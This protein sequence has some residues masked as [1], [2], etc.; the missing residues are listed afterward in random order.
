MILP[1]PVVVLAA[2]FLAAFAS[3]SSALPASPKTLHQLH[4]FR[5]AASTSTASLGFVR[6]SQPYEEEPIPTPTSA[7]VQHVRGL[8]LASYDNAHPGRAPSV[9]HHSSGGVHSRESGHGLRAR[10]RRSSNSADSAA[11]GSSSAPLDAMLL[12]EQQTQGRAQGQA[13]HPMPNVPMFSWRAGS[14]PTH[15]PDPIMDQKRLVY[16]ASHAWHTNTPHP[17]NS[18]WNPVNQANTQNGDPDIP[19][20]SPYAHGIMVVGSSNF[21]GV[22]PT[23]GRPTDPRYAYGALPPPFPNVDTPADPAVLAVPG[24]SLGSAG[25]V[26]TGPFP[27]QNDAANAV[28]FSYEGDIAGENRIALTEGAPPDHRFRMGEPGRAEFAMAGGS[29]L[30][31]GEHAQHAQAQQEARATSAM[32]SK[33]ASLEREVMSLQ[34]AL[35]ATVASPCSSCRV[36]DG[37]CTRDQEYNPTKDHAAVNVASKIDEKAKKEHEKEVE[38]DSVGALLHKQPEHVYEKK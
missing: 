3:S 25:R 37:I 10:L 29:F 20:P 6:A 26:P 35:R 27:N 23:M 24:R 15:N 28:P 22:H 11:A 33:I 8:G 2:A 16:L 36:K 12:E 38:A 14:H 32:R 30:E 7:E 9:R 13:R 4:R 1:S 31:E 19:L 18:I 17:I 34:S 21:P 5:A